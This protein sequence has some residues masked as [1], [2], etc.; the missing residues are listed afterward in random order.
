MIKESFDKIYKIV[1]KYRKGHVRIWLYFNIEVSEW[2]FTNFGFI[3]ILILFIKNYNSS[4]NINYIY[5]NLIFLD[6]VWS[7]MKNMDNYR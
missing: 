4:S 2:L 1:Y 7:L 6:T 5:T 3:I